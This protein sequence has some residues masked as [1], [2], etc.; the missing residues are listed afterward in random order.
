MAKERLTP[1]E[2]DARLKFILG[3]TLGPILLFTALEVEV[4]QRSNNDTISTMI[5]VKRTRI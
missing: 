4:A 5:L 2:L 1:V 3:C